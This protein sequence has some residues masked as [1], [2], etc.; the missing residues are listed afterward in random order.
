MTDTTHRRGRPADPDGAA[1]RR[2]RLCAAAV[3]VAAREGVAGLSLRSVA[4]EADLSPAMVG[5]E[6]ENKDGLLLAMLQCMHAH[7]REALAASVSPRPGLA[8][9]LSHLAEAFWAHVQETPDLQRVQYELTLHALT[10]PGGQA[11]ARAQYQGYVQ[12]VADAL[13]VA[14]AQPLPERWLREL[15]GTCVAIMDGVILQWLATG[16]AAAAHRQLQRAVRA[17]QAGLASPL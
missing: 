17:L 13:A 15:A 1:E 9:A 7:V 14:A 5:Y 6:F 3:A 8:H 16:D 4:A 10:L 11:L 12:A 2:R